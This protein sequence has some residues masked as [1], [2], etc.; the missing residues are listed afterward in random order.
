MALSTLEK[1]GIGAGIISTIVGVIGL[2][3]SMRKKKESGTGAPEEAFEIP[4]TGG[5]GGY[6]SPAYTGMGG[7]ANPY[8]MP[9]S[10]AEFEFNP[11][12]YQTSIGFPDS[13]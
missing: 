2:A 10:E 11:F 1:V 6:T 3:Y 8:F 13:R 5:G 12:A 4:I 7:A 9:P